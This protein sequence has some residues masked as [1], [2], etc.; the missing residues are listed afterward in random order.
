MIAHVAGAPV[1]E[2]LLPFLATSGS[3]LFLAAADGVRKTHTG[4]PTQPEKAKSQ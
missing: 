4:K 3:M 1:E 2:T